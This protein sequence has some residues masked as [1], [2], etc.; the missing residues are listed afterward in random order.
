M[1]FRTTLL[2]AVATLAISPAAHASEGLYAAIGAGLFYLGNGPDVSSS[3][4]AATFTS[5]ADYDNGIGLYGALGKKMGNNLRGELELGYRNADIDS[6]DPAT[7]FSGFPAT[8]IDGDTTVYTVMANLLYDFDVNSWVTPYIGGG[9]GA[10]VIDHDIV[11]SNPA[12]AP[13]SISYADSHT[14]LGY[15]GIAGLAFELAENLDFDVSYRYFSTV[16]R[17]L[18][19]GTING[20]P[21]TIKADV[22]SHN[23]FAGLRWSF[24][25]PS[26]PPVQYK[27]C[28]DGSSVPMTAE[29]PPQQL[30][31]QAAYQEPINFTVYFALNKANL[32]PQA[33]S[34][35]SDAAAQALEGDIAS[36]SVEGNTDTSGS[37]S[38]N[39]DLS[40]RRA[41]VV[42]DALIASDV[43]ADL[44]VT[45]ALGETNQ[46]LARL[47]EEGRGP[48]PDGVREPLN[49]RTEV[50][51][52]FD[53]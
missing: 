13:M 45:E 23:V 8:T 2:T 35:I 38:Y 21:A 36:V 27:D 26:A 30:E 9:V 14:T 17:N 12:G 18:N 34:L 40:E 11:G 41:S 48:T 50:E 33:S 16:K 47:A 32:T 5:K 31:E 20:A 43:P 22:N 28:W 49:R 25:A 3:A 1:K 7:G 37:A 6:I 51:I 10:A 19:S 15:Q 29:C 39:Q 46:N 42:R 24:G 4:G 44:I 52:T 53:R